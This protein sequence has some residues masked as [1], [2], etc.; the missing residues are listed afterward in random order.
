MHF[1]DVSLKMPPFLA[2]NPNGS[3]PVID[4][5]GLVLFESLAIT[6]HL[7]RTRPEGGLWAD[8]GADVSRLLQWTLW[9]AAE[10][11]PLA[12]QLF[13]HTQ[14]LAPELRRPELASDALVQLRARVRLV[15]QHFARQPYLLGN[16]FTVSD[17][18]LAVV[19]QRLADVGDTDF[20][21]ASAW[22]RRCMARPAAQRAMALR[23]TSP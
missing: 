4:D 16:R 6:L 18:N 9:A 17:L 14:F 19:L 2:L 3:L 11:E 22:H 8:N 20:P 1:K 10:A 12:R 5:G 7:A 21:H 15:D 13:H 23:Q